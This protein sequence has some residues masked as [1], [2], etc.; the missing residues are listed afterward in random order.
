MTRILI[1]KFISG[2]PQY[3]RIP[4]LY[5]EAL[6]MEIPS[7]FDLIVIRRTGKNSFDIFGIAKDYENEVVEL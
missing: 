2:Q 6:Q 7:N 5:Q 1:Q 4:R 3:N